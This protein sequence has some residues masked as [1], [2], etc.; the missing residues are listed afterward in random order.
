MVALPLQGQARKRRNS[1]FVDDDFLVYK[2][3]WAFLYNINKVKNTEVD[4][5][6]NLH[7]CEGLGALTTSSE[8]KPWV[9]PIPQ[10]ISKGDFY[11]EIEI[12]KADKIYIPLKAVSAKVLN[13]FK[14]IASFK[15]PEFYSKHCDFPHI[16]HLALSRVL[17]SQTTISPCLA[18]AKMQF[19]LS[20]MRME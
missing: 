13:H 6:L 15:N 1:V 12:T 3:Q 10:D 9:T 8:S 7:V 2:D 17:T 4:M 11:S 16:P 5:L 18:V 19:F 14:R 20:S